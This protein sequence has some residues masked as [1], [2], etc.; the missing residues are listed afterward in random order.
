MKRQAGL[1]LTECLIASSLIISGAMIITT[2]LLQ[3]RAQLAGQEVQRFLTYQQEL[4]QSRFQQIVQT[5]PPT[6]E[7]TGIEDELA[8]SIAP[9][10]REIVRNTVAI[11]GNATFSIEYWAFFIEG[12]IVSQ[13]PAL[14]A[15]SNGITL[16]CACSA[17][18]A[19]SY[20]TSEVNFVHSNRSS[21]PYASQLRMNSLRVALRE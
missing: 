20:Q 9:L 14:P 17:R 1:G 6:T 21:P 10:N 4:L 8:K 18:T 5:L 12:D 16:R 2:M 7:I 15:A 13:R 3:L 19:S 11:T